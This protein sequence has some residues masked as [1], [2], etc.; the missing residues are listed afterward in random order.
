MLYA[1]IFLKTKE[2]L[3]L[4]REFYKIIIVLKSTDN[5]SAVIIIIPISLLPCI[6]MTDE[7]Q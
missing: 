4:L 3:T 7:E 2:K 6:G 5:L 1:V